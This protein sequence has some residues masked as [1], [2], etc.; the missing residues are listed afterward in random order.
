VAE[1]AEAGAFDLEGAE[2][3]AVELGAGRE[4]AVPCWFCAALLLC[5]FG[6]GDCVSAGTGWALSAETFVFGVQCKSKSRS[7]LC[8]SVSF[9][10]V[11]EFCCWV[12]GGGKGAGGTPA[13]GTPGASAVLLGGVAVLF[14]RAG[15][16]CR[17][18]TEGRDDCALRKRNARLQRLLLC[19]GVCFSR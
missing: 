13:V 12:F 10:E 6:E 18:P 3:A 16:A 9:D 5:V 7:D 15:T 2:L 11:P 4:A 1:P 8:R 19:G 17:A 14:A